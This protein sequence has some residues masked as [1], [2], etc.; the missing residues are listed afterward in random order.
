[1]LIERRIQRLLD[2]LVKSI[3]VDTNIL[4]ANGMVVASSDKSRIGAWKTL[5]RN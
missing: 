4:D 1:M 2:K 5:L 3:Q